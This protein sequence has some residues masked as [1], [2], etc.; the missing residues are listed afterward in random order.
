MEA[1]LALGSNIEPRRNYLSEAITQLEADSRIRVIARS[2]IYET[3][4]VGYTEQAKFF[5]QVI[6]IETDYLPEGLLDATQSVE[7]KLGR[8]RD[9]RWGPRTID[10]DIL[11]FGE[12]EIDTERLKVPHPRLCERAFVLV[13]LVELAPTARIPG[14]AQTVEQVLMTIK[15]Q[16]RLGVLRLSCE[17]QQ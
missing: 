11:L 17:A 14:V 7:Q 8:K 4:P 1:Y 10:V 16:D 15:D 2:S 3:D 13:P 9:I 12:T 6:Q 5:N